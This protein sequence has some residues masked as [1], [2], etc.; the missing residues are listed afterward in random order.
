M[1]ILLF[2]ESWLAKVPSW[3]PQFWSWCL[4]L[5]VRIC[6]AP[7]GVSS[8]ERWASWPPSKG[9]TLAPRSLVLKGSAIELFASSSLSPCL[10]AHPPA[11]APVNG[12]PIFLASQA[13]ILELNTSPVSYTIYWLFLESISQVWPLC[14]SS[15]APA[16]LWCFGFWKNLCID[17]QVSI[18]TS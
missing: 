9:L 6:A 3:E 17:S 10:S 1:C 14:T 2:C 18:L 16:L 15:E 11:P 7:T 5:E 13:Q 8:G 12:Y 4:A